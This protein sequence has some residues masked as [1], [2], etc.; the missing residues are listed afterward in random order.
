MISYL[1]P[2]TPVSVSV[3][4]LS[5]E[6]N[7]VDTPVVQ[8]T[9]NAANN[10]PLPTGVFFIKDGVAVPVSIDTVTPA[11]NVLL[12]VEIASLSGPIN[13]TAGDLNVS[14][15]STND[16]MAIGDGVTG[17]LANVTTNGATGREEL[18]VRDDG[19][20]AL[21][22]TI[23]ADTSLLIT[24]IGAVGSAHIV[25]GVQVL[26][27][28]GTNNR[29]LLTSATGVLQVNTTASALPTGAATLTEQQ[30][31]TT[32][33]TSIRDA[34][35]LIDNA[36]NTDG[37]PIGTAG[38]AIGGRD[39]SN[40]F[41]QVSVNTAGELSVTFGSAGFATETTLSA[42]N[43]KVA[44]N[45]GA[46]TGAVRTAAQVGNAGGAADFNSGT[47]SA[48][49]LR[50]SANLKRAGNELAYNSGAADA[51]TLRNVLAT[52]HEAAATPLSNRLSDGTDFLSSVA[53]AAARLDI[54]SATKL[55]QTSSILLGWNGSTHREI[56]LTSTGRVETEQAS[57]DGAIESAQVSVGLTAVRATVDNLAPANTRRKLM[58][59]PSKNNTG[60]IFFG[61]S[62]VTTANGMEIIGPDRLEFLNDHS[63]WY[64]ISDTAAQVVEIIEV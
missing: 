18:H 11:N 15:S 46:A 26:G 45:F 44:N 20:I 6:L 16:S 10:T 56:S 5:F 29:R 24:P 23:D 58:I 12:P 40:A 54:A 35:E 47:D 31:Q 38:I 9:A 57:K 64:L 1:Y 59:K 28:D 63:D 42:L 19:A 8:D 3:P 25:P 41:Q 49:T 33:L 55:L 51:N 27:S 60:A 22:T 32:R 61:P 17:L 36:V 34:V 2:P 50:V 48:Q 53:L 37:N 7:G 62:T 4:P 39:G 52:R 14:T 30:T 13:I 43:T 21:L